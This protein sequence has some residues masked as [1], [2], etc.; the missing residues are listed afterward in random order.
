VDF[1]NSLAGA[2]DLQTTLMF[3]TVGDGEEGSFF[4]FGPEAVVDR[5]GPQAAALLNAKGGGKK[6]RYQG[7]AKHLSARAQVV[8]LLQEQPQAA[9]S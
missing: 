6:G 2:L 7:K 4:L 9:S 8:A 1:V 3:V 5:L